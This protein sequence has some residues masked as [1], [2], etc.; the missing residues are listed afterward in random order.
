MNFESK[1][2]W[3]GIAALTIATAALAQERNQPLFAAAQAAQ[4]AVIDTLQTLVKIDS[5]SANLAGIAKVADFA[6]ARLKALGARTERI[7]AAGSERVMLKGVL[8]GTGTLKAMLIAHMDTVYAEGILATEPYRMD[9]NRLYGPGIADDKG[10][11]AVTP[12]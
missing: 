7:K 8:T 12:R 1:S 5:G 11:I 9:G 10:G 3:A 4:P 6:E 2:V